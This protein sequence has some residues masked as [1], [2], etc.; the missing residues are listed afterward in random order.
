[1]TDH[2]TIRRGVNYDTYFDSYTDDTDTVRIDYDGWRFTLSLAV[3]G[4]DDIT[5]STD[6]DNPALTIVSATNP[7]GQRLAWHLDATQT[8]A[9]TQGGKL[10]L[11]QIDPADPANVTA[12]TD[13]PIPV[14]VGGAP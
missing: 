6:D 5:W 9:I 13:D 14:N 3:A 4:Q 10:T 1:M 8:R 11:L 7:T 12:L 2:L